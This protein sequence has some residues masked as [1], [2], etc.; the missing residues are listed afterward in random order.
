[1]KPVQGPK[2]LVLP[3]ITAFTRP[4]FRVLDEVTDRQPDAAL[5]RRGH[6]NHPAPP[7]DLPVQPLLAVGR[8]DALLIDLGEVVERERVLEPLFETADGLGEA[9]FV[10]VDENGSS[11]SGA[12]LVRLEP[13]LLQMGREAA[14]LLVRDLKGPCVPDS[15]G[16][17]FPAHR[18]G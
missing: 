17:R 15:A 7:A 5:D 8:G 10:F 3:D 13:D 12:L 9:L 6:P 11:S 4:V 2:D 18:K 1:M 14:L 16:G